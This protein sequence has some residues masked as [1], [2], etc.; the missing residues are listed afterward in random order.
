MA[1]EDVEL[2][3]VPIE[4]GNEDGIG[5]DIVSGDVPP[6]YRGTT[7]DR[8]DMRVLGNMQVLRRN[9]KPL[10]MVGFAN[11]VMVMWETFLVTS[12]TVSAKTALP[13]H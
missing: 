4:Y 3:E 8:D 5:E 1:K 10:G 7:T 2:T 11:S 13:R 6:Q 12:G 9:F